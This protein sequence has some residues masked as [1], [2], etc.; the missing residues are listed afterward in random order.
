M[1]DTVAYMDA[2]G[3]TS[4]DVVGWSD[5]ATIGLLM[6]IHHPGRVRRLVLIGQHGRYEGVR[7]EILGMLEQETM[8]GLPPMLRELYEAV[9]PDG[10]GHWDAAI[11]KI[12][13]MI[14]TAPDIPPTDLARV[15]APTLVVIAEQDFATVEYAE[16]M[17][18]ALPHGWLT[19][20][21]GAT[22]GLPMEQ[23]DVVADLV[24]DFLASDRPSSATA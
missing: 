8:P 24:L 22:H 18:R 1:Q 7:P 6:A 10:P 3:L 14:R 5:G 16:A 13:Q 19:V 2:V 9:S 11:A 12:W 23:P 20:V 17:Q 15:T 21:S 4:A